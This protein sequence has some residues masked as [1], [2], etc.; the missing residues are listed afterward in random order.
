MDSENSNLLGELTH[1]EWLED[2]ELPQPPNAD[3]ASHGGVD[4]RLLAV[5]ASCECAAFFHLS[6][7]QLTSFPAQLMRRPRIL[8]PA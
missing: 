4:L 3:R 6:P 8:R 2:V 1:L 5:T 7:R